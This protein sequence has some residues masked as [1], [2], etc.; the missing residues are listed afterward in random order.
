M[1]GWIRVFWRFFYFAFATIIHI[2][3]FIMMILFGMSKKEAGA[4]LRRRWLSHVPAMMGIRMQ[5]EGIPYKGTCLYVSNHIGYI[6]P[7][8]IL[9]Q[10]EANVVAKAEILKW[11]LVGLGGNMAG[12]IFVNRE[13]KSSRN[14]TVVAVQNALEEGTSILIFPEGTTSAGNGTLPFRPRSFQAAF[15]ADVPVQPIA[16]MYDSPFVAFI[17]NHTFLPHFFRLFRSKYITGRVVFGPLLGGEDTCESSRQWIE[18]TLSE[19]INQQVT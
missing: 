11:P 10:V 19:S 14:E 17:G 3:G 1:Q 12:T 5:M 9:I 6:D 18:Q 15:L 7:F 16:I 4:R 2:A 8:V 13:D